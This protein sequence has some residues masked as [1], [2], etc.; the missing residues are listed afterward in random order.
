M[1][2]KSQNTTTT[3]YEVWLL[4]SQNDFVANIPLYLQLIRK[5]HL[6]G[7]TPEQ[8]CIQPINAVNVG[9]I[10]GTSLSD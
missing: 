6:Q 4:I 10:Y 2:L 9:N 3:L 8:L 5:G 1:N 7:I